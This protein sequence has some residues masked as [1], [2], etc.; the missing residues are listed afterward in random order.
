MA[1][2]PTRFSQSGYQDSEPT[3]TTPLECVDDVQKVGQE[4]I[5]DPSRGRLRREPP[6]ERLFSLSRLSESLRFERD[7]RQQCIHLQDQLRKAHV[8]AARTARLLHVARSVQRTL[9]ECII[10]EDKHSFVNLYN[11]FQDAVSGCLD[12]PAA[13]DPSVLSGAKDAINYPASFVDGLP[14]TS[15][16]TLLDFISKVKCDAG[17]IADHLG[18]LTPHEL[19]KLLPGKGQSKSSESIFGGSSRTSSRTSR[20]LGFV[21]DGQTELLTSLEYGSTLDA[22]V[23][24]P[25]G[26]SDV[27]L[28]RDSHTTGVWSSVCAT[29]IKDQRQGSEKFVPAL[30]DMWAA[31]SPWRGKERLALWTSEILQKGSALLEQASRQS[32]RVRA[33][34]LADQDTQDE[35]RAEAFYSGSV[36]SF[37]TILADSDGPSVIPEGARMFCHAVCKKLEPFPSHRLAFANFVLIRWLSASFLTDAVTSPEVSVE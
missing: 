7:Q 6:A 27:P 32:F 14:D 10:A 33:G 2:K 37:L 29:L 23:H 30:I 25:R 31:S 26:L 16:A 28:F 3:A 11:A 21:A 35:N 15:R 34:G 18:R 1:I 36:V 22:L 9:G 19:V 8:V 20:H 13:T 5:E 4:S 17:F 12:I 24:A